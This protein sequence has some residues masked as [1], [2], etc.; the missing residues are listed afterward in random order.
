ME[1][2]GNEQ[3]VI[4]AVL[5]DPSCLPDLLE[6]L[7]PSQFETA[8]HA[9][10]FRAAAALFE[11]GRPV[12]P[13]TI[14]NEMKQN[15][16]SDKETSKLFKELMEI[17]PTAANVLEYAKNVKENSDMKKAKQKIDHAIATSNSA[18]SLI[19]TLIESLSEIE[20]GK[21]KKTI[22]SMADMVLEINGWMRQ[23]DDERLD[24]GYRRLDRVLHGLHKGDFALLAAR[25]GVGK[26]AFAAD[27]AYRLAKNG[28]RTI[29]FSLE[30]SKIK[31]MQRIMAKESGVILNNILDRAF[32]KNKVES[33]YIAKSFEKI[34]SADMFIDDKPD[35]TV[36]YIRRKLQTTRNVDFIVIDYLQLMT[37]TG[38][39]ENRNLEISE[40]SRSLKI[41]AKEFGIP[42]LALSQMNRNKADYDEPE[43]NDLRESG[44]LE[45]DAD[46]IM[47]IWK[48]DMNRSEKH[49]VKVA[50]NRMGRTGT[51]IMDFDGSLMQFTET[52]EEY[53]PVQQGYSRK[54]QPK[55][56]D[57]P[58]GL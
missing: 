33:S 1:L 34:E 14:L 25:P 4:G 31:I 56:K 3:S 7:E 53:E 38:K 52:A 17:T 20:R 11:T 48:T 18:D 15:G 54:F 36:S 57:F 32:L 49:G 2:L 40:I 13:V 46:I 27:L 30:M 24:T 55:D 29:F 19:D 22:A 47:F 16:T 21:K 12:D 41:L 50:K 5:I 44:S 51:V 58:R 9:N 43:K 8:E 6:V 10:T 39:K 42:I 28:K 26:S 35:V 23:K 45:Q 37:T